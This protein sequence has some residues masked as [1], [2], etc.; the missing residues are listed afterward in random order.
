MIEK[1]HEDP[2]TE[3][4]YVKVTVHDGARIIDVNNLGG[5]SPAVTTDQL[6]KAAGKEIEELHF[7]PYYARANRGGSGQM[8]VGLRSWYRS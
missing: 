3:E 6:Q 5:G 4:R 7:L 2:A 8:R 1:E